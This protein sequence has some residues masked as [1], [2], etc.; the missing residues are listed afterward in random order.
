[1]NRRRRVLV[2]LGAALLAWIAFRRLE[3][4]T[5]RVLDFFPLI[6]EAAREAG[7]DPYLLAG[8]VHAE[9]S[10]RPGAGK[11]GGGMGLLQV[12]PAAARDAGGAGAAGKDLTDLVHGLRMGALYLARMKARFGSLDLALL[13][14]RLGPTRV[15]REVEAAGGPR[16]YLA[17]LP[18][19][20]VGLYVAKVKNLAALYARIAPV[21]APKE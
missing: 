12:K 21:L 20:P 9:S 5:A 16:A 10:G 13:A 2:L 8:L 6:R 7:V 14:Y 18:R 4:P 17:G 11:A 15:A 19:R 1:M 3:G